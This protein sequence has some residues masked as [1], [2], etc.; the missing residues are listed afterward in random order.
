MLIVR[1]NNGLAASLLHV[2]L[3]RQEVMQ[4]DSTL[5][6]SIRDRLLA[7]KRS[8]DTKFTIVCEGR[9]QAAFETLVDDPLKLVE[10]VGAALTEL[11]DVLDP[12]RQI[13]PRNLAK[14]LTS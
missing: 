5:P 8:N 7:M 2:T 3:S 14:M 13:L 9:S 6:L 12:K 10:A 4:P 11:R 1:K